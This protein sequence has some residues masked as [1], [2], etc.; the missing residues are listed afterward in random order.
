MVARAL[1]WLLL[2]AG[3]G[4]VGFVALDDGRG[5]GDGSVGSDVAGSTANLVSTTTGFLAPGTVTTLVVTVPPIGAGHLV[6]GAI[7]VYSPT[8]NMIG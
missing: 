8:A 4:R 5:G 1:G 3:C 2:A 7:V 6:I